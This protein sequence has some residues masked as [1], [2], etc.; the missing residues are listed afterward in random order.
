MLGPE[1]REFLL[2]AKMVGR[3]MIYF[4]DENASQAQKEFFR[5]MSDILPV[6]TIEPDIGRPTV[7]DKK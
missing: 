5:D 6:L 4:F 2:R 3:L 1:I 7:V